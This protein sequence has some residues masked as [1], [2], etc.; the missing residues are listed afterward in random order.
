[1]LAIQGDWPVIHQRDNRQHVSRRAFIALLGASG[2][3]ALLAACGPA[4]PAPSAPAP[5][6]AAQPVAP[7]A[8]AAPAGAAPAGQPKSGGTLTTAKLGDYAN[9]DGHYWS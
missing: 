7:S 3:A 2:S 9:I 6:T 5:T 1:M 8:T 4:A